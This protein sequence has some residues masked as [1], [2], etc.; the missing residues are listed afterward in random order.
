MFTWLVIAGDVGA[1]LSYTAPSQTDNRGSSRVNNCDIS[2]YNTARVGIT[3]R[4]IAGSEFTKMD[5]SSCALALG[6]V[7][8]NELRM[9]AILLIGLFLINRTSSSDLLLF[10][11][12]S[13]CVQS[14]ILGV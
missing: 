8:T 12:C 4:K 3:L 10:Q 7:S 6:S 9:G 14:V 13:I 2:F 11:N 5:E 1:M